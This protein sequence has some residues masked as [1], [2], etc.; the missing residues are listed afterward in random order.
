M[1]A[2]LV[3]VVLAVCAGG[4]ALLAA[5]GVAGWANRDG[6]PETVDESEPADAEPDPAVHA[7]EAAERAERAAAAV[8]AARE[9]LALAEAER[10]RVE[11][12]Y[13]AAREAYAAALRAAQAGRDRV[14]TAVEED[15]GREVTRAA[16]AAYRR[17]EISVDQLHAVFARAGRFDPAQQEREREAQRLAAEEGLVRLAYD[18][19]VAEVRAASEGLHVAEVAAAAYTQEA[20]DA[21]IE[22][23]QA[24]RD[25]G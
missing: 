15:R 18:R 3:E 16:M 13:D 9:R 23:E 11:S 12:G 8:G 25:A 1:R 19:A 17:G 10:D 7:T 20:V 6:S 2:D 5:L 22:A 4:V 21:A 14:P 24:V